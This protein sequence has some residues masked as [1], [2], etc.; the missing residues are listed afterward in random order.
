MYIFNLDILEKLSY[1][2]HLEILAEQLH[3]LKAKHFK[4]HFMQ[5]HQK[6]NENITYYTTHKYMR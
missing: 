3:H 4:I 5:V 1:I 2:N 6:Q